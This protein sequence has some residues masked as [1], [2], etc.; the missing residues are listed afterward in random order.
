MALEP[1]GVAVEAENPELA[2]MR[3]RFWIS[4]VLTLPLL[5]MMGW[6][7]FNQHAMRSRL[8]QFAQFC[9]ATPVV[10]W[11]GWPF[12]ERGWKSVVTSTRQ[13]WNFNMF[14]LIAL[15]T[16]ISYLASV[17]ALLRPGLMALYFEPAAV[18]TTLVLLGQVLELKARSETGKALRSLLEL[19]PKMARLVGA[20]R[21]HDIPVEQ[22]RPGDNL[23]VRPGE[24]IP[25]DG[26]VVQG[27]S[28]IDESALTGEP[29]PVEKVPGDRVSAGTVNGN[30]SFV[31]RAERVGSETLLNQIVRMV[32]E[33]QR[34]HA[35]LQ[36]L[37]DRVSAWFVPLVLAVAALT[38][39]AWLLFG[40]GPR[41]E[42]ALVNAVAV[43]I[44]ACPCA[45]GLATPMAI[46]A[47]TGRGAKAGVLV[48]NAEALEAL[49]RADVLVVDK[50]GTLTEGKPVLERVLPAPGFDESR[51]LQLA[52][53]LEAQ[54]E[55]P[56]ADA[57]VRAAQ[58][59][60]LRLRPVDKFESIPGMGVRGIVEGHVVTAGNAS[61]LQAANVPT[62]SLE[63]SISNSPEAQAH[64]IVLL[65]VDGQ[66][67][68]AFL[69]KDR[70]KSTTRAAVRVLH[71]DG[72]RI[73]IATGDNPDR[74]AAI[75]REMGIAEVRAGLLPDQKAEYVAQ[76]KKAGHWVAMAG[77]GINDAPALAAAQVGIAMATGTDIA[78]ETAGITLLNGDL[79]G[80]VRALRLSRATVRNIRQNLFF[81]FVYNLLG[82][83]I[84]GGVLYP[85]FGVLLSPFLQ[86]QP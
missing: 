16:G 79:R 44:I 82:V 75:A 4:A 65:A 15:G 3:R 8:M 78:V 14:T 85:F 6:D 40:P 42:H 1:S 61:M 54:S 41:M 80:V 76:L 19:T 31:M 32:G 81:A 10:L 74:A 55:H 56:L 25:V 38:F 22:V 53:S 58:A 29:L 33:A 47:G 35:P 73:A 59:R 45:L 43:L 12:F 71:E 34:T 70:I 39:A 66:P 67:A 13:N 50:T 57:L 68:A 83:P 21:E 5:L 86:A 62:A 51:T 30:G 11:G 18:I 23:R 36:R 69:F 84:A 64:S 24:K 72:M 7:L 2:S 60:G 9:L 20:A 28:L 37:A 27:N 26:I 77:D 49:H 46:V 48:R 63:A 52:A 17:V